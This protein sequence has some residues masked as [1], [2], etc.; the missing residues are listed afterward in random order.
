MLEGLDDGGTSVAAVPVG[1]GERIGIPATLRAADSGGGNRARPGRP[2]SGPL[3]AGAGHLRDR[4]AAVKLAAP[5]AAQVSY[6]QLKWICACIA[7]ALAAH[8]AAVPVWLL[9]TVC[10]A[11]AIRLMLAARGRSAPGRGIRLGLAAIAIVLL[12]LQFHTFNGLTA[13]TALLCLMAGLKLLETQSRRDAQ[14]ITLIIYFLCVA[15]LLRGESFWLLSYLIA[16]FVAHHG[17]AA[18][19]SATPR[20]R[21]TGGAACAMP[22]A[23]S[24]RRCPSRWSFGC[25]SRASTDRCGGCPRTAAARNRD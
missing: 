18:L 1:V 13:G 2:A 23:S 21:R 22:G 10:A 17:D 20:R 9:A 5:S 25:S 12:F 19:A 6:A 7:L 8:V 3:P 4:G 16:R 24:R 15:A 11:V 14:I